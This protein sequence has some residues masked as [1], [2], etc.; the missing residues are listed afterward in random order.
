MLRMSV[1]DYK[2]VFIVYRVHFLVRLIF[3]N[4][5]YMIKK[6]R[7]LNQ[8]AILQLCK[9]KVFFMTGTTISNR[10]RVALP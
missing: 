5:K 7:F 8:L 4:L 10:L 3:I 2:S 9:K 1:V 6:L